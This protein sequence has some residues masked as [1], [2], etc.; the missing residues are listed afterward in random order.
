[1]SEAKHELVFCFH[2]L[3]LA[4]SYVIVPIALFVTPILC[5]S[6][7]WPCMLV[8]MTLEALWCLVGFRRNL[9]IAPL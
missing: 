3:S 9:P 5:I 7:A 1:M 2:V 8:V 4:V 6:A